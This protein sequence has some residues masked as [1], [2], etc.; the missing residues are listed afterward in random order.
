MFFRLFVYFLTFA[1]IDEFYMNYSVAQTLVDASAW[2]MIVFGLVG[3]FSN[4]L[5]APE[6]TPDKKAKDPSDS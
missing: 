4:L 2:T 1:L 6:E 5:D 3:F